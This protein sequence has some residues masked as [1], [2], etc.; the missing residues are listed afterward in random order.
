MRND[1]NIHIASLE[2][3]RL[4]FEYDKTWSDAKKSIKARTDSRL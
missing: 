4:A 1:T 2:K 3:F